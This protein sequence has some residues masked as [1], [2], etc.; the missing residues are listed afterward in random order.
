M[1]RKLILIAVLIFAGAA[2]GGYNYLRWSEQE[3]EKERLALEA[4]QRQQARAEEARLVPEAREWLD[5]WAGSGDLLA[6]AKSNLDRAIRANPKNVQARIEMARLH[7]KAGHI[8]YRNFQPGALKNAER[9]LQGAL[10]L[11]PNS[12]DARV[13]LGHV[14]YLGYRSK[15]ALKVLEQAEGSGTDNP[16]LYLNWTDAL[17]DLNRWAEAES[18]LNKAQA[19]LAA[20]KNAPRGAV[21]TMHEKMAFVLVT[22]R[23][24]DEADKAYQTLIAF[25]PGYAWARGNYAEFL[26]FSRGMPDAAI[27]EAEKAIDIMNYGMA[28]LT[29][30]AARYAKWAE[31]K[32]QTPAQAAPYLERAK[33]T[34]THFSWIMP[35]AAKSVAAGPA[36]QNMVKELVALGVPL[37]TKDE[38]GDTGLTLAA[39]GGNL[40]SVVLL[41]KY[42]ANMEAADNS[43][44]TA[45]ACATNKG[46]IEVV[47]ALAARGANVNSRDQAGRT[48]LHVATFNGDK[49]MM[50]TLISLKANANTWM[51]NGF[52]P[53]MQAAYQGNEDAVPLLLKAGAD[54]THK[55]TDSQQTAADFA[56]SRGH[57]ALATL[58]REAAEK[59]AA[60]RR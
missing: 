3:K 2:A 50:R 32:L 53:L 41:V 20:M 34:S 42:K 5:A 56:T 49:E 22:Q 14:Y 13:L 1:N 17:I 35:Q 57:V 51:A 47:K 36:I 4:Q 28:Q 27:A 29:L 9:E 11:E 33:A 39:D 8:N 40:E 16:W 24:L 48:P 52:T 23:K 59:R 46:H 58:I 21:R 45:L 43:G 31:V 12:A 19:Q 15:E 37:D 25:D 54:P 60:P 44:Q 6:K 26:L 7:I 18:R 38:L 30:A 55:T 10:K